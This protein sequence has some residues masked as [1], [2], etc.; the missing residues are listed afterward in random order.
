MK[1][2]SEEE[3]IKETEELKIFIKESP[4]LRNNKLLKNKLNKILRMLKQPVRRIDLNF[5]R[6][7]QSKTKEKEKQ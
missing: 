1:Y 4:I 3:I 7:P 6:I 5:M 2:C